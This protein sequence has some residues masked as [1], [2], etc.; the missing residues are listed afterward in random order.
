MSTAR[1]TR[2]AASALGV[3]ALGL[4]L[5]GHARAAQIYP[6]FA[7]AVLGG[8]P[9]WTTTY[10]IELDTGAD[11]EHFDFD[12]PGRITL[13]GPG[14]LSQSY[15]QIG[16]ATRTCAAGRGETVPGTYAFGYYHLDLPAWS[17]NVIVA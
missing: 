3:L 13:Q 4:A 7:P 11:P 1:F 5:A 16:S 14:A 2:R 17:H 9:P 12:G 10:S 15:G 6:S 8:S